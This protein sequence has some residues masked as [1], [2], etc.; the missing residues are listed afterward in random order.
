MFNDFIMWMQ[1]P[2]KWND[3]IVICGCFIVFVGLYLIFGNEDKR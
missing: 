1:E 3:G 2:G